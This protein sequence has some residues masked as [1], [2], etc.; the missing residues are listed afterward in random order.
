[1]CKYHGVIRLALGI[2]GF[3]KKRP[4]NQGAN[5]RQTADH[6]LSAFCLRCI[7]GCPPVLDCII[8]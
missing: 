7:H 8:K 1:V 3:P 6:Y 5:A 4:R 2:C